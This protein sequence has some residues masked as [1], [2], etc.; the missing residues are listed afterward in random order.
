MGKT[1]TTEFAFMRPGPTR[2]PHDRARTPGGSSSGSAAAVADRMVPAALATQTGGS[3]IRPAAFCGVLGYKPAFGEWSAAG[4]KHLAPSLD[5]L[6][7]YARAL[8]DVTLISAVLRGDD[9]PRSPR[10]GPPSLALWETPYAASAEPMAREALHAVADRAARAGA[11][12]RRMP[13]PDPCAGLNAAH[14]VI[15]ASETARAFA[16]EWHDERSRLSEELAAFIAAGLRHTEAEIAEAW[17]LTARCRRWLDTTLDAGELVLTLSV[18]GEAPV[19]IAA[20]GNAIFNRLWTLL[21]ATC[22]HIPTGVG[23]A[24]L[25][26]GVQL[27]DPRGSEQRTLDAAQWLVDALKVAGIPVRE[28]G[29]RHGR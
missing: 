2:N 17:A 29:D 13:A 27:V 5:T 25:P 4:L 12:V 15:M 9:V 6:G 11:R 18:P 10:P 19:G 3:T 7:L 22:L 20:T 16:R 14:R 28:E 21:H 26:I 1:V 24:G 8:E 23:P